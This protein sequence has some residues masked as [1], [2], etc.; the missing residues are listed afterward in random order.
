MQVPL[1]VVFKD[2]PPAPELEAVC[3]EEAQKLERYYQRITACRVVVSVPHRGGRH[4]SHWLI[5]VHLAVPGKEI[6]VRRDPPQRR[7]RVKPE[8]AVL[9]AFNAARRQL[10][11]HLRRLR[12]DVK[13][14]A[15][16][17]EEPAR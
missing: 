5:S 9:E 16:R 10:E 4:G 8:R 15:E 3:R 2:V 13:T 14:H 1:Q 7:D 17:P 11:D 12:G 6:V